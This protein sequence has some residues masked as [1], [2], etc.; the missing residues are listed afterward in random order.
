[1]AYQ[2][3]GLT[4]GLLLIVGLGL[5]GSIGWNFVL[6]DK[7]KPGETAVASPEKQT[8]APRRSN[9]RQP[10]PPRRPSGTPAARCA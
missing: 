10:R 4:K 5:V 7:F 1:M 6:K 3:T 8:L 9:A 2:M